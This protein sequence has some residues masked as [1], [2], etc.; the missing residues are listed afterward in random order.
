MIAA[1]HIITGGVIGTAV[2][3]PWLAIPLAVVSHYVLDFVPHKE[4][5][6][7]YRRLADPRSRRRAFPADALRAGT[8]IGFGL[9]AVA[10]LSGASSLALIAGITAFLPDLFHLADDAFARSQGL[11]Y[12]KHGT[13]PYR[14]PAGQA[15]GHATTFGLRMRSLQRTVH[16]RM[17]PFDADEV[18]V[19]V[20]F[21][22]QGATIAAGLIMLTTL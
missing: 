12:T 19:W 17:Q 16:M 7:R 15:G 4:Y 11:V 6:V 18:P 10:W 3:N 20:G 9:I 13:N 1:A 21:V 5:P 22:T 14:L 8:D 2:S